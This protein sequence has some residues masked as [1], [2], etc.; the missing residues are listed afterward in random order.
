MA[1][2][3][4]SNYGIYGP[5]FELGLN[6]P[7][8]GV[9]EY[10][11][12]EKYEIKHWDWD[13]PG[14]LKPFITKVNQIRR[15]HP[16]LHTPWNVRFCD[17]ANDQLLCYQKASEDLSDLLLIAVNLD[18]H[19]VQ[20]GWVQV[21]IREWGIPPDTPYTVHDLLTDQ[22]YVWTGEYNYIQLDPHAIPAH[23]LHVESP[24]K[25]ETDFDP[26]P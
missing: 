6:V 9:E 18:P 10:I 13:A 17:I 19:H 3:L 15:S 5:A 2:T 14:N 16:A 11:D 21:P 23:I 24:R 25:R 26:F 12:N 20:S 1:A 8:P 22:T 4:S 7:R